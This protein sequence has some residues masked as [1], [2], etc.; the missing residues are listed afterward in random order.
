M[1]IVPK[2][3]FNMHVP[4]FYVKNVAVEFVE[5]YKYLGVTLSD[6][7]KDDTDVLKRQIRGPPEVMSS[8]LGMAWSKLSA[9]QKVI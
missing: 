3:K 6:D 5:Q 9:K 4:T 7:T 8:V 2:K 1:C